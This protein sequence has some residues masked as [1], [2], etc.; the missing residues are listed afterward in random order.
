MSPP[1]CPPAPRLFLL[2]SSN[3]LGF[4]FIAPLFK[5]VS[6][7]APQTSQPGSGLVHVVSV[8]FIEEPAPTVSEM[9]WFMA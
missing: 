8:L 9:L 5:N 7:K 4:L 2:F 1:E 6:G 3:S